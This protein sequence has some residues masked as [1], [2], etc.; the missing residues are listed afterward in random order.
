MSLIITRL[1][2][3]LGNQ[4]F[5]FAAG[6]AL[7]LRRGVPLELDVTSYAR[8]ELRVYEL[9]AFNL[10]ATIASAETLARLPKKTNLQ[11][12]EVRSEMKARGGSVRWL[13]S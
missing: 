2:G 10:P 11:K 9:S 12:Q 1:T 13:A 7:S 4:M 8:D 3:G 6:Y 5:Q